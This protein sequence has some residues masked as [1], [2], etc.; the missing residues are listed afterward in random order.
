MDDKISEDL[1]EY[2]DDYIETALT[3]LAIKVLRNLPGVR[4]TKNTIVLTSGGAS[5]TV[6]LNETDEVFQAY[7]SSLIFRKMIG[8]YELIA[9]NPDPRTKYVLPG[10][11]VD[12]GVILYKKIYPLNEFCADMSASRRTY[13]KQNY[14]AIEHD[15]QQAI[16]YL[17]SIGVRHGDTRIDNVGYDNENKVFVL[18]DYDKINLKLTQDG[19]EDDN[20][21]FAESLKQFKN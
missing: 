20:E 8:F 7:Q 1:K 4:S 11:P 3:P 19:M 14:K 13:I 6:I 21:I 15:I 17:H 2:M 18:F 12:E 10:R 5:V 16:N 9:R